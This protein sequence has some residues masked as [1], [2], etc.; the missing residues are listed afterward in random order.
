[1]LVSR[2]TWKGVKEDE[3]SVTQA[4]VY[5]EG[6]VFFIP[7]MLLSFIYSIICLFLKHSFSDYS[8]SGAL[9]ETRDAKKRQH[10]D[11]TFRLLLVV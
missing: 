8:V 2:G 7:L 1:M 6:I 5:F 11:R 9:P 10:I 3:N 4:C